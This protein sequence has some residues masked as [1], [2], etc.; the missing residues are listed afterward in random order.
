[1]SKASELSDLESK[2]QALEK[3]FYSESEYVIVFLEYD[4]EKARA[5]VKKYE[6]STLSDDVT[7]RANCEADIIRLQSDRSIREARINSIK[8]EMDSLALQIN[9]LK[10]SETTSGTNSASGGST[11]QSGATPLVQTDTAKNP[12][13]P[14]AS[15]S[16]T[17]PEP[18]A[19]DNEPE[20]QAALPT[21]TPS[22]TTS[23]KPSSVSQGLPSTTAKVTPSPKPTIKKRTITCVKGKTTRKVTAVRPVCP[24][25]FKL[26]KN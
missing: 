2:Y 18:A 9:R 24:K 17:S 21:S 8:S 5:C 15:Q 20:T 25:G 19:K 11:S 4:L 23:Q 26:K 7:Q 16:P 3:V 14:Q 12:T 13:S 10:P 22:P 6:L 1:M